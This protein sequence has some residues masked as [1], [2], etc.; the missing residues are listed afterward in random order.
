MRL[1]TTLFCISLG[2]NESPGL[3]EQALYTKEKM[4]D[5]SRYAFVLGDPER[6]AKLESQ[7]GRASH[8]KKAD[9]T[10]IDRTL[11]ARKRIIV[12]CLHI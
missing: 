2:R 3:M 9:A 4:K 12:V 5:L 11:E 8:L 6:V 1:Q 7:A 10:N